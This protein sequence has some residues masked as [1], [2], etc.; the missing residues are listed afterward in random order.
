MQEYYRQTVGPWPSAVRMSP[1]LGGGRTTGSGGAGSVNAVWQLSRRPH[2]FR[3]NG[4]VQVSL[5]R[6]L[7]RVGA[8]ADQR[9]SALSQHG[10]P[11]RR[12]ADDDEHAEAR[13]GLEPPRPVDC[14]RGD[15]DLPSSSASRAARVSS[16]HPS[17][18]AR[19]RVE[20]SQ[21]ESSRVVVTALQFLLGLLGL[22]LVALF[23]A[24][25]VA[26]PLLLLR[27]EKKRK[28][29]LG[30]AAAADLARMTR[31]LF[32][33]PPTTRVEDG[34][35]TAIVEGRRAVGAGEPVEIKA[36]Y[37][38]AIGHLT[39]TT[40]LRG[41]QPRLKLVQKESS[42]PTSPIASRSRATRACSTRRPSKRSWTTR[43][44]C[45]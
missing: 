1:R 32:E 8:G 27:S 25:I 40:N 30:P 45:R 12:L 35:L 7:P 5:R 39:V 10:G 38:T 6:V 43:C 17:G 2:T 20:S 15:G 44:A 16:S 23:M 36:H 22:G 11:R 33:A 19:S 34:G 28:R 26:G 9:L 4:G 3:G 21:V 24:A 14:A 29:E 31:A 13:Q 42:R 41:A 37:G 18:R